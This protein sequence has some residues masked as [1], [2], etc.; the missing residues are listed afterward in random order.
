MSSYDLAAKRLLVEWTAKN[1]PRIQAVH[2][3]TSSRFIAMAVSVAGL[4]LELPMNTYTK[5]ESFNRACV[6]GGAVEHGEA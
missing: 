2:V 1:R 6:E 3:L 4:A 5:R